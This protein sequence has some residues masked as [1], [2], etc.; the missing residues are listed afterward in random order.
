MTD[1][2]STLSRLIF[3]DAVYVVLY[4]IIEHG[5]HY[6]NALVGFCMC[7]TLAAGPHQLYLLF[8]CNLTFH[9]F[10]IFTSFILVQSNWN[11]ELKGDTKTKGQYRPVG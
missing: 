3:F 5:V 7:G 8:A 10:K 6:R 4:P 2:L 9:S 11:I 1:I